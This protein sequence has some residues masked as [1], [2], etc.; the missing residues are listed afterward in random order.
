MYEFNP[1]SVEAVKKGCIC[2][3]MDN[4]N[5]KGFIVNGKPQFWINYECPLH[6][7]I[8]NNVRDQFQEKY[9]NYSSKNLTYICNCISWDCPMIDKSECPFGNTECEEI[10][11]QDWKLILN[12]E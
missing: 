6:G 9:K 11:E 3:I 10:T 7:T 4:C 5:G 1:G 2:P 12:K 8:T